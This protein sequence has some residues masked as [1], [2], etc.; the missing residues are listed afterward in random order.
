MDKAGL[1]DA[2][3]AEDAL[4]KLQAAGLTDIELH[5]EPSVAAQRIDRLGL[6][7]KESVRL[8]QFELRVR[9]ALGLATV[10]AEV[11]RRAWLWITIVS[12]V[13]LWA[14][15]AQHPVVVGIGALLLG[16][17]FG[18]PAW[19]F[20]HAQR[21][22]GLLRAFSVG[23]WARSEE[24]IQA[25]R[26]TAQPENVRFDL[27]TR[28]ATIRASQGNVAQAL[29]D[30]EHWRAGLAA[31]SP[32]LFEARVAEVYHAAGDYQGFLREMRKAHEALPTDPSRQLDLALAEARLGDPSVA[33]DFLE[34]V[35][36]AAL[37]VH[38]RPFIHWTR[39]FIALRRGDQSAQ[40]ELGQ[41]VAGFLEYEANPAVWSALGLC[42]GAYA[43]ALARDGR[44]EKA[45]EILER[46]SSILMAHG[47]KPLIEM[48]QREVQ[49][50]A[51][52]GR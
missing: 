3:S 22:D 12:A 9:K 2:T 16:L 21:Y 5:D 48:I 41:A 26:R 23:D 7:E 29:A 38:G 18:L 46:V 6:D 39:G 19:G 42:A 14:L 30:V 24:L 28:E 34:N 13:M 52:A 45:K 8:A 32:G 40:S 17:T 44:F 35:H 31:S 37:P 27:D 50:G 49:S 11:A 47:D 15:L 51:G 4:E 43:L 33:H 20:R 1:I 10:L 36:S 25:L